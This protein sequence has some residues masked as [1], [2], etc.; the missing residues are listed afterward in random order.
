M[1]SRVRGPM[2]ERDPFGPAPGLTNVRFPAL[3]MLQS[4][5]ALLAH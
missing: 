5:I 1:V 3:G 2:T 4:R